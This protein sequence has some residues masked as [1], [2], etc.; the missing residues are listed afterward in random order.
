[1]PLNPCPECGTKISDQAPICPHCGIRLRPSWADRLEKAWGS[2]LRLAQRGA[3]AYPI[4]WLASVLISLSVRE[5]LFALREI[6]PQLLIWLLLVAVFGFVASAL[7]ILVVAWL[8]DW[9][10]RDRP[11]RDI[12]SRSSLAVAVTWFFFAA[13]LLL[14]M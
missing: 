2:G 8:R 3:I 4:T 7:A 9:L 11:G 14:T 5:E 6:A 1:M 13:W 12:W 10:G